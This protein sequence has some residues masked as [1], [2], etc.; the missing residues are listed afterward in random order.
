MTRQTEIPGTEAPHHDEVEDAI[1]AWI[2]AK[3]EQRYAAE[4]TKLRHASLL[5]LMGNLGLEAYPY[6]DRTTGKK[7]QLVI[8]REPK[9]KAINAPK[10]NRRD[11]DDTEAEDLVGEAVVIDDP[12]AVDNKIERRKVKRSSVEAE[13]DPFSATR[14]ALEAPR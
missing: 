2:D 1:D 14:G 9:A 10:W 5:V 6:V 8:A 13:L 12:E 3:E 4:K 7:K 11:M